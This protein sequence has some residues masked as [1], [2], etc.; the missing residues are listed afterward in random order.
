MN[1]Q[2]L[3]RFGK[4]LHVDDIVLWCGHFY[5]IVGFTD[6]DMVDD[7]VIG[8]RVEMMIVNPGKHSRKKVR[9]SSKVIKIDRKKFFLGKLQQGQTPGYPAD[10]LLIQIKDSDEVI[11]T[12]TVGTI[13]NI[14]PQPGGNWVGQLSYCGRIRWVLVHTIVSLSAVAS[15]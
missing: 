13:T 4:V 8:P 10:Q 14:Q 3:D 7:K 1:N 5:T 2:L 6:P 9:K 15:E 12:N 11:Y